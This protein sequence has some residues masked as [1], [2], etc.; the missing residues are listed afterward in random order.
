M[1]EWVRDVQSTGPAINVSRVSCPAL[2]RR[3]GTHLPNTAIGQQ[4]G[5][6]QGNLLLI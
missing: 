1:V 5:L 2:A 6:L 4:R 3:E